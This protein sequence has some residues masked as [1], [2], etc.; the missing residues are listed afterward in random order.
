L[1]RTAKDGH[2]EGLF[3][4]RNG[5]KIG[6]LSRTRGCQKIFYRKL[7]K[8]ISENLSTVV[9]CLNSEFVSD[10]VRLL[11]CIETISSG[12][13]DKLRLTLA[14][15]LDKEAYDLK[16]ICTNARGALAEGLIEEGVEIY[17]VGV[18]KH[19]FHWS[20]H[21]RVLQIIK[22]YQPHIVHG[23]VFEGNTM[24]CIGGLRGRVP[25]VILEETSD[26]QNRSTKANWLL[27]IYTRFADRI[28]AISPSVASYL[29]GT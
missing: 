16:I 17:E 24:A 22:K 2:V 25:V 27:N 14:E 15:R 4:E 19:P 28:I 29:V 3:H 1:G 26:P 12:G 20:K 21:A 13:V 18:F 10:K 11:H 23:A 9:V 5:K 7:C 8:R 6:R